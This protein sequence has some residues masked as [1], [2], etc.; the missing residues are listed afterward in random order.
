MIGWRFK[1]YLPGEGDETDFEKLLKLFQELLTHTSGN[2]GEALQWLTQLDRQYELTNDDYTL[3]D[4]IQELI[5]KNF[6][7]PG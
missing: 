7:K 6:I 1:N 5:D 3:A 2:V 4:F